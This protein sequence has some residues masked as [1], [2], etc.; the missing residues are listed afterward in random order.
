MIDSTKIAA[1]AQH[2]LI[3]QIVKDVVFSL[4]PEG[5]TGV[6]EELDAAMDA[7]GA[8]GE[9]GEERMSIG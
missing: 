6:V 1:E 4:R 9:T 2:G 8:T 5:R 7:A 3:A